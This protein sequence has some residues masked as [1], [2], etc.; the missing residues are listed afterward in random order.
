MAWDKQGFETQRLEPSGTIFPNFFFDYTNTYLQQV[1]DHNNDER[2]AG[3]PPPRS[4]VS[5]STTRDSKGEGRQLVRS[6][7]F[8]FFVLTI[9]MVF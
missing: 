1:D 8:L 4:T 2:H 6:F 9:L 7:L 3:S 5:E